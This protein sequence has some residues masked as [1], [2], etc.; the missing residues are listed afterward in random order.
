MTART[1]AQYCAIATA[2]DAVGDRW[3]LLV[4]RELLGGPKRYTDLRDG[5]PGIS[6]DVLAARLREL[7]ADG[8][9][10]RRVLPPPAASK[11]YQ[12]SEEGA[13][14]EPVLMSLARWGT[15]RLSPCQEGEFRPNWLGLALRSM[16][17]PAAAAA[18]DVTADFVMDG[19]R[20]RAIIQD[21]TLEVDG[22]PTGAADVVISGD[23]ASIAALAKGGESRLAVLTD[24]RVA[25]HGDAHAIVALRNSFGLEPA[26]QP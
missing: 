11:V 25:I 13:G 19:G 18:V 5:L 7:E 12:L 3:A 17:R 21:G 24:G 23:P 2:L 14:L 6:T 1:Y 9:V 22:D 15:Q 16:F 8:I 20:L 26:A 4:V 10:E